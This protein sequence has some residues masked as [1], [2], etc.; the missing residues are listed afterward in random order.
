VKRLRYDS[1]ADSELAEAAQHYATENVT[2]ALRFVE[3]VVATVAEIRKAPHAWPLDPNVPSSLGV[4]RRVVPGFPY[5]VLYKDYPTEVVVVAIAHGRR[6]PGY[7]RKR[8]TPR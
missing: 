7:W 1:Q 4:R 5:L 3:R 2:V 6:E 8:L